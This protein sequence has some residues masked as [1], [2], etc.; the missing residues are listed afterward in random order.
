MKNIYA[1]SDAESSRLGTDPGLFGIPRLQGDLWNQLR[2]TIRRLATAD[3]HE[4]ALMMHDQIG[5]LLTS[6]EL[7]E[8]YFVFPGIAL[9]RHIRKAFEASDFQGLNELVQVVARM[10]VQGTYRQLDLSLEKARDFAELFANDADVLRTLPK[11]RK[12]PFFEVLLVDDDPTDVRRGLRAHRTAEDAFAF[13]LVIVSSFEEALLAVVANPA[14]A[15]CVLRFS[16]PF[17]HDNVPS[18]A[19]DRIYT[20]LGQTRA[21]LRELRP[22]KR[23]AVLGQL[24]ARLRPELDLYRVTDAPVENVVGGA[25]A[26]FDRV[27]YQTEDYLDLHVSILHGVSERFLTPFFDAVR[28]YAERPTGMFH[29]LPVSRGRTIAKSR[30]I[31]DFGAFYGSRLFLA[32]TSATTGGLDSLLQPTGSLKDAQELAARAFG[33]HRT[34]FVTNG[35]STANKIVLQALVRP[36]DLVLLGH[37]CHKSHPYATILS[38]AHPVY[39]DGYPV[40][41]LSMYGGVPLA[42][43]KRHLLNIRAAG[44]LS[45]VRLLLLTNLTFDGI[46]YDPYQVMK[47]LLAIHPGLSFVWDEAWFAY[48]R[49]SPL[50]SQRTAMVAARRLDAELRSPAYKKTYEAWKSNVKLDD[51]ADWIDQELLPD[52]DAAAVRVY[53]TQ[54]THKTLTALRQGSMIHVFDNDFERRVAEPFHEA[55]MTHTSTSPNYQILASLDVGRRQVEL[56]GYSFVSESLDLAMLLRERLRS[57]PLLARYFKVSS[58]A[59]MIP[60]EHRPSGIERYHDEACR[61]APMEKAWRVDEFVLDPTRVTVE[62]GAT[63]MDGDTFKQLLMDRYAIHVN[64]TSRNS[65]LFLVHIGAARGTVAHLVK[66]LTTIA[67]ETDEWLRRATTE[68]RTSFLARVSGLTEDLPPLPNFSSFHP[69]FEDVDYPHAGDIRRAYFKAYEPDA[70]TYM[71]VDEALLKAVKAGAQPVAAGFVTPYPPGFPVLIPGQVVSAE[72][73]QY[74]LALDVSEIHGLDP[75][76]GLRVF[77]PEVLV[78]ATAPSHQHPR[79]EPCPPKPSEDSPTS[80]DTSTAATAP[81]S[82]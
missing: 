3:P 74:V 57:D 67:E 48:G 54:S 45:R 19:L 25:A 30:W 22:G 18:A 26:A 16:F 78:P 35:T 24:M 42:E 75:K 1:A 5:E 13:E 44:A 68:E 20:L 29:A 12:R 4:D 53:A 71:P 41:P 51:D 34:F 79:N 64:K 47:E 46:T 2:D 37:D 63:G 77:R 27:F 39:L 6:V 82:S 73:L 52:P 38:G 65:V 23:T 9:L 56:E 55:Y 58:P 80:V 11:G 10:R 32:E 70:C 81:S 66:V 31:G 72:I 69:L 43:I 60:P 33:A 61:L 7:Y 21:E 15:A 36:Q 50:L 76:L 59:R 62:V 14:I 40:V 17:S 49:F 28:R 8:P